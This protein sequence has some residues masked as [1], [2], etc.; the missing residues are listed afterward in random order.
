V[1]GF[2]VN[3]EA[4]KIAL[5]AI[6]RKD[7]FEAEIDLMLRDKG[8]DSGPVITYLKGRGFLNDTR[9]VP[10]EVER[11]MRRRG[12][13]RMRI[14]EELVQRGAPESMVEAALPASDVAPAVEALRKRFAWAPDRAK[15]MRFLASRGF[16]EETAESAFSE[17]F[18]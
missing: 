2:P 9:I 4:L 13:G 10:S 17:A 18:P 7:R 14:I 3:N 12:L 11:L 15:A 1:E 16:D 6:R 8:F 5:E